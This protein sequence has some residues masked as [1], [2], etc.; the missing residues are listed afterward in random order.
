M[1][2]I[3]QL[4]TRIIKIKC[5]LQEIGD[6]HPGSLSKQYNI[7]GQAGCRCKDPINPKKHGPYDQ[8]SYVLH[9]KSTSRFIKH[10]NIEEVRQQVANY[11]KFKALTD[12]WKTTSAEMTKLK[13]DM[14]KKST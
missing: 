7:C 3:K 5:A 1:N 10:E 4:E 2:K 9:G 13:L 11:K 8:L 14:A 6:M 12:S